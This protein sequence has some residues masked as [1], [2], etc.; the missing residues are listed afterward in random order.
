MKIIELHAENFKRLKAITI[1]PGENNV[2]EVSGRNG[3]G[4]SSAIDAI[5]AALQGAAM[6]KNTPVPVRKG[7]Q[8]AEIR[9]DLGKYIVTRKWTATGNSYLTV[10]TGGDVPAKVTSPQKLLD[11]L[12]GDL[13]FDP[14]TFV[15]LSDKD[16]SAALMSLLKLDLS[17]LEAEREAAYTERTYVNREVE[18]AKALIDSIPPVG[19]AEAVN[20]TALMQEYDKAVAEARHV[21]TIRAK[22]AEVQEKIRIEKTKGSQLLRQME[23]CSNQIAEIRANLEAAEKEAF[24]SNQTL[25]ALATELE[26]AKDAA[27]SASYPDLESI[28][29]RMASAE[30]QNKLVEQ[31]KKRAEYAEQHRA[32]SIKSDDLTKKIEIAAKAKRDAVARTM[33]P[34][35]AL[36]FN[37]DSGLLEYRGVPLKQASRSEQLRVAVAMAMAQHPE[38]RVMRIEDASI[39]DTESM[40]VLRQLATD[41]DYQLWLEVVDESGHVGVYIED[42]EVMNELAHEEGKEH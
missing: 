4:K 21:E 27:E 37:L 2:I 15:R 40:A 22:P 33:M 1:R 29:V 25:R 10:T 42:G 13:C 34:V 16:Q 35:D 3:A 9:L 12:V 17:K 23:A 19:Q 5:W 6:L 36:A 39:L 38:L 30:S 24:H 26:T 28:K 18:K 41:Q 20:V 8:E 32:L 11:S 14:L 7:E 31:A